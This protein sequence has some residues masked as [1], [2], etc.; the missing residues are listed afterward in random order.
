MSTVQSIEHQGISEMS[1][2]NAAHTPESTRDPDRHKTSTP[3]QNYAHPTFNKAYQTVATSIKHTVQ[4]AASSAMTVTHN[5]RVV[6]TSTNSVNHVKTKHT[7]RFCVRTRPLTM[8][9][10]HH[11]C[12]VHIRTT[13]REWSRSRCMM[14]RITGGR[15]RGIW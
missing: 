5:K 8:S 15:I 12:R 9:Q 7:T 11:E 6:K 13:T 4:T 2:T 1:Q 3:T 10:T 14:R